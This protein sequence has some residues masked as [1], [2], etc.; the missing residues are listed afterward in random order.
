MN[1]LVF[2]LFLFVLISGVS[3]NAQNAGDFTVVLTDCL[4]GARITRYNGNERAVVI[5]AT[6]EDFSVKEIGSGA[7]QNRNITSVVIPD[8]VLIIDDSAFQNCSQLTS[9]IIPGSVTRIN[10]FVFSGCTSLSSITLQVVQG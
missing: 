4:E 7:F 5:P 8:S 2:S 10:D 6:I 1:K 9:V 3:L